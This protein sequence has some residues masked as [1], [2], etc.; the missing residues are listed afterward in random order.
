MKKKIILISIMIAGAMMAFYSCTKETIESNQQIVANDPDAVKAFER[1]K[2]FKGKIAN[3]KENPMY[4]SGEE[5][6]IEDL[7]WD[8]NAALNF[9]HSSVDDPYK[10]FYSEAVFSELTI[11]ADD[12]INLDEAANVYLQI[13]AEIQNIL[14]S[15]PYTEKAVQFTYISIEGIEGQA[16]NL[17]SKTTIGE[18]GIK[19]DGPFGNNDDWMYGNDYGDCN[20]NYFTERDGADEIRE[21]VESRRHMH[22]DEYGLIFYVNPILVT[23]DKS[24]IDSNPLLDNTDGQGYD[25]SKDYKVFY[26]HDDNCP[27]GTTLEDF[28]CIGHTDMNFYLFMMEGLIYNTIPNE[29]NYWPAAENYTFVRF[30]SI[31]GTDLN[32]PDI[33]NA[34]YLIHKPEIIFADKKVIID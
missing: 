28:E 20:G 2:G 9:D 29:P 30:D 34:K 18:K 33:L 5:I 11:G 26:A 6:S 1:I 8:F 7:I 23:I 25:N 3:Y 27:E 31:V 17:K 21:M 15:A 12:M 13:E 16:L 32:D 10:Q 14:T 24:D 22:V 4:K 19:N